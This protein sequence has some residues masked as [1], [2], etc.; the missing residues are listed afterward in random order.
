MKVIIDYDEIF[1]SFTLSQGDKAA[2][3]A[4]TISVTPTLWR[5][6]E[7]AAAEWE[8]VQ[9]ILRRQYGEGAP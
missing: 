3:T 5:R 6:Y 2:L 4:K 1:P 8:A 9:A 7:A